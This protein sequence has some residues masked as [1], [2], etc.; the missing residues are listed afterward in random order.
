MF[1]RIISTPQGTA[2][3]PAGRWRR[4]PHFI[5]AVF[6]QDEGIPEDV[7]QQWVDLVLPLAEVETGPRDVS[8][9][10]VDTVGGTLP[11]RLFA[12]ATGRKRQ[13]YGYVVDAASAVSLL[14]NKAPWAAEWWRQEAGGTCQP[15]QMFVFAAADCKVVEDV[16]TTPRPGDGSEMPA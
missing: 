7:R 2:S 13:G 8:T 10:G 12:I 3:R 15:G 16:P 6:P 14:A 4:L 11:G 9:F 1:I 5:S